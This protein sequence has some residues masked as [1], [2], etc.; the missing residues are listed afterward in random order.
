[1]GSGTTSL[2]L[3]TS[4]Q[5][6]RRMNESEGLRPTLQRPIPRPY[7]SV[8]IAEMHTE[9][10]PRDTSLVGVRK[11][12]HIASKSHD[13]DQQHHHIYQAELNGVTH[14]A[15]LVDHDV[16]VARLRQRR[17]CP[18]P[19][20][21]PALGKTQNRKS[22]TGT[23]VGT[24]KPRSR[25]R[26]N[27]CPIGDSP[28]EADALQDIIWDPAS[29]PAMRKGKEAGESVRIVEISEIVKRIAPN[30]EKSLDKDSVL[31]WIGD[32]AIPCT[33]EVQQP[34]VRQCSARSKLKQ[35]RQAKEEAY[36]SG[37]KVLCKQAKYTINREIRVA[38]QNYS[39]KLKKQL[40]SN[41]ST[42][43]WKGL[44]AITSYK[45]PSPSTEANQQLAE[46]LNEF[47][48]RFEKQKPGLTPD[49]HSDYLTTRPSTPSSCLPLTVPQPVLKICEDDVRKVFSKQ[50]IRKA[51]GPDGVSPACLKA[52]AV[53]LSSIFTLIF[54]RSLELCEVPSCFKCYTI[55]PVPKKKITGLNDYRP[56]ALTSVVMK[57]FERLVL[58]YL[59]DITGHLLDPLQFAYRANRSVDDAVNMGVHYI[60]QHLDKPGTYARIL[61]VDFS[62]AFNTIIPGTLLNKLTQLP[63]P[64]SI[65]QWITSFLTD[66]QKHVN[67][68]T[69]I[70]FIQDGDESAYRQEFE[71]L[72][73]WCSHNKLE[74]NTLKTVEMI[75]DFRRNPPALP[76]LTIMGSTVAAV[77][78]FKFL[79]TTISQDLKW[80]IQM[81]SIVKKAQQ[82]LYFLR[83]LKKFNL[84]QVQ[85]T[86][87]YSAV[88]E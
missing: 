10:H 56:I 73:V 37:D 72:S 55:I 1:M 71:Q 88:I 4:A 24:P 30:E 22:G 12:P 58:A 51:K 17:K 64:T 43:V 14:C 13:S 67:D 76:P 45:T 9:S 80:D 61:F 25:R 59:K 49:T 44:K 46:D 65:C 69:I 81:D 19:Y 84:P 36:R 57:S 18:D 20:A 52:C 82:R 75:V 6:K 42:S 8:V 2:G 32:S 23:D 21:E 35:L 85:M 77:E 86:E 39:E 41:D 83:P 62:S 50:Q 47:Y 40:S 63:V 38:K 26:F 87:F 11:T 60:L 70:G 68:T 15:L 66:R 34:R 79:G 53:Q 78:S 29:P 28:S 54:N 3:G 27:C 48:C 7:L 74:L 33:P 31:H 5:S 16:V